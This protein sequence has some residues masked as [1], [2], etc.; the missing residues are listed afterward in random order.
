MQETSY[1]RHNGH[2]IL[3]LHWLPRHLLS[4]STS[5]L[6][7]KRCV[8]SRI[9]AGSR[10]QVGLANSSWSSSPVAVT[11]TVMTDNVFKARLHRFAVT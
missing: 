2:S 8:H 9:D 11:L 10:R 5:Q 4:T 3:H 1:H 6:P 7:P